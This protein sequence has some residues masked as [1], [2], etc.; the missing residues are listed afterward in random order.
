MRTPI[1][2][3]RDPFARASLM[4]RT[5]E[6]NT[7]CR[8]CGAPARFEYG[9]E[10]DQSRDRAAWSPPFCSVECFRAYTD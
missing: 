2:I 9:W 1:Q 7:E 5:I 4:R 6:D 10:G 8:W 3:A